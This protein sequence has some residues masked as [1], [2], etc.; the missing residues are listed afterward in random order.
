MWKAVR[1]IVHVKCVF[2]VVQCHPMFH[3]LCFWEKSMLRNISQLWLIT[4]MNVMKEG[5][6]VAIEG[7]T[8]KMYRLANDSTNIF[9]G[10]IWMCFHFLAELKSLCH[11]HKWCLLSWLMVCLRLSSTARELLLHA[12]LS[13]RY[14]IWRT[15]LASELTVIQASHFN[16]LT[17]YSLV[18]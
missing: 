3:D 9:G 13:L 12:L 14:V 16:A 7:T 15:Y 11:Q 5:V 2:R 17:V 4:N 1:C 18:V 8:F 6:Y 10:Q